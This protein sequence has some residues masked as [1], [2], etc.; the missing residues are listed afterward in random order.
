MKDCFIIVERGVSE[1]D[2]VKNM[3]KE[4]LRRYFRAIRQAQPDDDTQ[5][6][7]R[8]G[9]NKSVLADYGL[10]SEVSLTSIVL[11]TE[12]HRAGLSFEAIDDD[13]VEHSYGPSIQKRLSEFRVVALSTTYTVRMST[14]LGVIEMIRAADA[15]IPILLGG[16]GLLAWRLQF[17]DI[18]MMY[19]KL[20]GVDAMFFGEAEG[21]F[22]EL[23]RRL[24]AG[25][26]IADIPGAVALRKPKKRIYLIEG[27]RE[28]EPVSVT[29]DKT[30]LP[31]W[32]VLK[33]YDFNEGA[34]RRHGLPGVAALEEGRGCSFRCKFCSYPLY[35]S[36]RRKSPERVVAE[37]RGVKEAGFS[38]MSFCGAEFLNPLPQ[39]R[40]VFEA[41]AA[42]AI[43]ME[44]WAYA[45]I[46]LISFNPWIADLMDKANFRN[47]QFG[48][49]SGDRTVLRAMT[50]NY[51]P[52]KMAVGARL[53]RERNIS[54]YASIILGYPGETQETLANTEAVLVDCNF[55]YVIMHALSVV[56]G[57]P[58]WHKR[59]EYNLEVKH[60]LWSHP[61]MSVTD[62][63]RHVKAM[64]VGVCERSGSL[65]NNLTQNFSNT[66][67]D[68]KPPFDRLLA[69][70]RT[71][72]RIIHNEWRI[73]GPDIPTRTALWKELRAG[74]DRI[75]E[76]VQA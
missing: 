28:P 38:S 15:D 51:D 7:F 52:T 41:I 39:S 4:E 61:T 68:G 27:R 75:P 10:A 24:A 43:P 29:L 25:E 19:D 54:V 71:L 22:A 17:E 69:T 60:G 64:F 30:L 6:I 34:I 11:A 44:I 23:V 50:K 20:A 67:F 12:L 33:E 2:L 36:F 45:R 31:D 3:L 48:M 57:S 21:S 14:I 40:P 37:L 66:F 35:A 72:Q 16:Q 65:I 49:E 63:P 46:D 5:A 1:S 47:I 59:K 56:P 32:G 55:D 13:D 53:L 8:R 58:L 62:L 73:S 18:E 70:T 42:S 76:L 74:V 9:G 26:S